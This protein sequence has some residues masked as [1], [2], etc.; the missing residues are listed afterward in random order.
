MK[1]FI[2]V[3]GG[4][5][6]AG[7]LIVTTKT[8]KP[9]YSY[10]R[11]A[12]GVV[13]YMPKGY[14]RVREF[15]SPQYDNPRTNAQLPDLRSTIYWNPHVATDKDGQASFEYF[16]ADGKGNYRVVIE[17]IDGKGELGRKVFRY[18]VE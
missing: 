13:N 17:G 3:Y 2:L 9:D 11:Y 1:Q 4:R 10:Q 18:K 5:G 14:A 8:G 16:N 15:Y 12:P 6:D 7:L